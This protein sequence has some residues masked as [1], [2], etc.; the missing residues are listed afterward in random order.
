MVTSDLASSLGEAVIDND[1]VSYTIILQREATK[2]ELDVVPVGDMNRP[3][4]VHHFR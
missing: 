4:T 2:A 1:V 3:L